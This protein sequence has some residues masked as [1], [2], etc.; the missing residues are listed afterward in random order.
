M[1][2]FLL[3]SPYFPPM[4][5]S[6]A[7]RA[8]HL[9][10]TMPQEGW[11]PVVLAAPPTDDATDPN[12]QSAVPDEI[13]V[14][15]EY[16][17]K[18]RKRV[19][20]QGEGEGKAKASSGVSAAPG[21]VQQAWQRTKSTLKL[22]SY[23]TPF[24]RYIWDY[25]AAVKA[26]LRLIKEYNLEVIYACGDPFTC[27]HVGQ[28]LKSI[29]GLPLVLDLRDPWSMH[30]GK[31]ALRP[32][33]TAAAVR[34]I[35]RGF[36]SSADKVILNTVACLE[37]HQEFYGEILPENRFTAIRNSYDPTLFKEMAQEPFGTFTILYFGTLRRFVALDEFLAGFRIFLT[38]KNL[39][40]EDVQLVVM[41][42]LDDHSIRIA[43]DYGVE[44][45]LQGRPAV[46]LTE[47][48]KYLKAADLLLLVIQNACTLQIPGKLY[49]YFASGTP[50]FAVS[51]NA[52]A[53]QMIQDSHAGMA[54]DGRMPDGVADAMSE[55]YQRVNNNDFAD[56][57]TESFTAQ[58]AAR[59][60]ATVLNEV[61]GG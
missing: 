59:K 3:I 29:T 27:F 42:E 58:E 43:A 48:M 44:N 10:R 9:T 32:N 21:P 20:E 5:R 14:Y 24:D 40:P 30:D 50:I 52:E 17:G 33:F 54:V 57:Q 31:M 53:N 46:S 7:K 2:S 23:F 25:K 47:S 35:E 39:G 19:A 16:A 45:Y 15:R 6:G 49:D 56:A 60:M 22:N 26:G 34:R 18:R 8:L 36:F 13:R 4:S 41:G 28:K 38:S 11:T 51:S 61:S 55:A 1:R 37:R 12:L